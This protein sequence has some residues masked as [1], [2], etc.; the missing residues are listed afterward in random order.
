MEFYL[1]RC[2]ACRVQ[3]RF[4]SKTSADA[5]LRTHFLEEHPGKSPSTRLGGIPGHVALVETDVVEPPPDLT[6]TSPVAR[7]EVCSFQEKA[8]TF[9]EAA[10]K[11]AAHT[12]EFHPPSAVA[13][14]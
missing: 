8:D 1:A 6:K 2:D 13:E 5:F 4:S 7:C 14:G 3:H 11:L 12:R 9:E 10:S